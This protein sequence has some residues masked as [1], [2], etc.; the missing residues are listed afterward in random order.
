[1]KHLVVAQHAIDFLHRPVQKGVLSKSPSLNEVP[2]A[3]T[4]E[5]DTARIERTMK[6]IDYEL[7]KPKIKRVLE[8]RLDD[9]DAEPEVPTEWDLSFDE[10]LEEH[11]NSK[12]LFCSYAPGVGVVFSP[13]DHNGIWAGRLEG[14]KGKGKL[15][16]YLL[17]VVERIAK[18]K[19]LA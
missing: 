17:K 4:P 8:Q 2:M 14:V 12:L 1:M 3:M 19:G 16:A 6:V 10:Y 11:K 7:D 18:E 15:P 5:M 13:S 9:P